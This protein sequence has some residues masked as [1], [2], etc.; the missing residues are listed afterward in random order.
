MPVSFWDVIEHCSRRH[1]C[2]NR[3]PASSQDFEVPPAP[4][5][6][7]SSRRCRCARELRSAPGT[8]QPCAREPDTA[9]IAAVGIGLSPEGMPNGLGDCAAP[10]RAQTAIL[11]AAM[12][13]GDASWRLDSATGPLTTTRP[14][15][16]DHST[17]AHR[18]S[19]MT[20]HRPPD[21][22]PSPMDHHDGQLPLSFKTG[23]LKEVGMNEP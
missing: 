19:T 18:P 2:V 1:R 11:T 12:K 3:V 9:S 5:G 21:P 22:R 7:R 16:L 17:E 13:R 4:P 6:D 23:R 14:A 8:N 10:V 20:D 15:T